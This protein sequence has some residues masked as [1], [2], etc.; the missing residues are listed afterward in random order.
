[1][2]IFPSK[3]GSFTEVLQLDLSLK[4]RFLVELG[5]S[6]FGRV[7]RGGLVE[8]SDPVGVSVSV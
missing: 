1:M 2:F 4:L 8:G 5:A 3:E 6:G 7:G